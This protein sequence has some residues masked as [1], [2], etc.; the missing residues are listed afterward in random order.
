[1]P[2]VPFP[3]VWAVEPPRDRRDQA[4]YQQQLGEAIGNLRATAETAFTEVRRRNR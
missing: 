2:P 1:M 3:P 4:R